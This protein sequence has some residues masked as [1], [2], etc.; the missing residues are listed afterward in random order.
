VSQP[1]E[2]SGD[3]RQPGRIG[4]TRARVKTAVDGGQRRLQDYRTRY[5]LVDFLFGFTERD[6]DV[7]G[8]VISSA[9]AFRFFLVLVPF[10][11]VIVAV[12]SAFTDLSSISPE[13]AVDALGVVGFAADAVAQ[14][15]RMTGGQ[16]WLSLILG[17]FAL[18]WAS[19]WTTT[20]LRTVHALAWGM[21]VRRWP[22]PFLASIVFMGFLVAFVMVAAGFN[23]GAGAEGRFFDVLGTV[24]SGAAMGGLWMVAS[25]LLPHPDV[26][27]RD[28]LPGAVLVAVGVLC[29]QVATFYFTWRIKGSSSLYGALGIAIVLLVW[30]YFAS[31]LVVAA[32]MLNERVR[33]RRTGERTGHTLLDYAPADAPP[34]KTDAHRLL[35]ADMAEGGNDMA[36]D[37]SQTPE[38]PSGPADADVGASDD[39]TTDAGQHTAAG[40]AAAEAAA[41]AAAAAAEDAARAAEAARGTAAE[42][43]AAASAARAAD[44]AEK[45]AAAA[46]RAAAAVGAEDVTATVPASGEKGRRAHKVRRWTALALVCFAVLIWIVT[47]VALWSHSLLFNTDKYVA[48]VAPVLKD[49]TVTKSLGELIARQTVKAVGLRELLE[50]ELP[51]RV[52]F[53]AAPITSQVQDLLATQVTRLLRTEKAYQGWETIQRFAHERLVAILRDESTV[54]QL[55]GAA[56]TLDLVPLIVAAVERLED[57]LPG[58]IANNAPLPRFDPEATI[59]EQRAEL[60][61]YL[62]RP[63]SPDFGQ[64]V[65]LEDD[66]VAAAQEAIKLFDTIVWVLLGVAVAVVVAALVISPRRLRTLIQLGAGAVIVVVVARVAIN[67]LQA[68]VVRN[69]TGD[70]G[71]IIRSVVDTVFGSLEQA[72]IW[73]LIGGAIIAVLAY[74]ASMPRWLV[75][76]GRGTVDWGR[77]AWKV[78]AEQTSQQRSPTV[79]WIRANVDVL[80]IVIGVAAVAILLFGS[81]GW[82]WALVIVIVAGGLIGGLTWMDR[83]PPADAGKTAS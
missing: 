56:V 1:D 75:R 77:R 48:T 62:G 70:A 6:R 71:T 13:K 7:A 57:I 33:F 41:E 29:L 74:I 43:D 59:E 54:V 18:L 82:A 50:E 31:R 39:T 73:L 42:D 5:W 63:L 10:I 53:V 32:A 52:G 60:A 38:Q 49:P 64:I 65:L 34:D 58:V 27:W 16:I 68:A 25:W 46:E 8:S 28:L 69:A 14:A 81:P 11:V 3:S 9:L 24:L 12:I 17:L 26:G 4:R 2:T 23:H 15:G 47:A 79:D 72:I 55:E 66:R 45:A 19:H 80:R 36:A 44:A 61:D 37:Q 40:D 20:S 30:L 83:R 76:A 67:Q 21:T 22:R 78:A 35:L 51:S